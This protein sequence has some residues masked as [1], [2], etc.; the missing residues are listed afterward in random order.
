MLTREQKIAWLSTEAKHDGRKLTPMQQEIYEAGILAGLALRDAELL[1]AVNT[2][3]YREIDRKI[4]E[5][6]MKILK[7]DGNE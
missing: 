4:K 5:Q 7:G 1:E 3:D 2:F 6:F